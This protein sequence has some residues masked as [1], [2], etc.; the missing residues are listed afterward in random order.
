MRRLKF[1]EPHVRRMSFERANLSYVVRRTEDQARS[2]AAH[3]RKRAG[4][5]IVY[6]RTREKAETIT[7]FLNEHGIAAGFY[8]GGMNYLMRS[9]RQ[10]E[11]IRGT[12]RVMVATNAF[13]MG[14]DK[15]DVRFVVHYDACDS[16]EAYYQEAG[17]AGRDG[18]PGLR[19]HAAFGRRRIES[20]TTHGARLSLQTDDPPRIRSAVQLPGRSCRRRPG[21]FFHVQRVRLRRT[22]PLFRTDGSP[23][24]QDTATERLPDP[25]RRNGQS[26]PHPFHRPARRAVPHPGGPPRAGPLHHGAAETVQRPVQATSSPSPRTNSRT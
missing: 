3:R 21:R 20:G 1:R 11:W 4:P 17:R 12:T 26:A 25:D 10:D 15:A 6:V 19:R 24:D 8:H 7:A 16:L 22:V 23:I 13:G 9:V 14:I 5:G 18:R 2:T